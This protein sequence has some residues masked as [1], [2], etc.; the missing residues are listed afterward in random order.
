MPRLPFPGTLLNTAAVLAGAAVGLAAGGL[1]PAGP[2]E[3][4]KTG[5]GLVTI[6]LGLKMAIEA[7]SV[8]VLAASVA[9]GGA[10]GA[11]AGV[12]QGIEEFAEWARQTLGGGG[13]FKEALITTSVLFCVGP[14]TLLGCLQDGLERKIDLLAVKSLLDGIASVLFA[15]TLGPGV[16]VTAAVVLVV[17]GGLTLGAGRLQGIARNTELLAD[18]AGAGGPILIAIGLNLAGIALIPSADFL[19]ALLL[20]PAL[21]WA[22]RRRLWGSPAG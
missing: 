19:P 22:F 9:L 20:A 15:A 4:A 17:Q 21:S 18:A 8:L 2:M 10:L 7:K 1:A 6:L 3:T 14:M 16:L 12:G 11:A 13:T 5:L